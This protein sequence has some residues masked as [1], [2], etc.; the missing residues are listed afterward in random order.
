MQN[1]PAN[2]VKENKHACASCKSYVD[3]CW[4]QAQA[5]AERS[6]HCKGLLHVDVLG[7]RCLL[8]RSRELH[9]G[10]TR[11][12]QSQNVVSVDGL[13][14]VLHHVSA[15][16]LRDFLSM[17][18]GRQ[19]V[20]RSVVLQGQVQAALRSALNPSLVEV[21]VFVFYHTLAQLE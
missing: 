13:I 3:S 18:L 14:R 17:D 4:L 5:F 1:D 2:Q 16:A 21:R 19:T 7:D 12:V 9:V 11:A 20:W 8:H 6:F 10:D 15:N